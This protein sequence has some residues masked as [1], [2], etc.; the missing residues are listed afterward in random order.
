MSKLFL[1][2]AALTNVVRR[3]ALEAGDLILEHFDEG[4]SPDI[5]HKHD[6]SPVTSA[7]KQA[8]ALIVQALRDISADVPVIGEEMTAAGAA[9]GIAGADYV[10]FVDALDGTREFIEGGP[11]FTVNIGL[12]KQGMPVIGV[13]YAPA[14]GELYAG[15]TEEDGTQRALRWLEETDSEKDIRV[16][17]TPREGLTVMTSRR[18]DIDGALARFLEQ[19]K[20][21]KVLKRSSSLKLCAI[22]GG[23]ADLY[24]RFGK[25]HAWDTAAGHAILNAAGGE[26][27]DLQGQPLRYA[28]IDAPYLN[29]DFIAASSEIGDFS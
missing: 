27:T 4:G 21:E 16:R 12:V 8:E 5:E 15:F 9:P 6:G 17:R 22:A 29:P 25:T 24:P 1:H 10:W 18:Q 14:K 28:G 19:F 11:D 26:I 7:D 2:R 23:K 3:I 13:V 20:I